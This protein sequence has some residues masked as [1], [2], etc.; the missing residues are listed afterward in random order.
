MIILKMSRSAF[1]DG[2]GKLFGD[3]RVVAP[4]R[5]NGTLDYTDIVDPAQIDLSDELPYKSPKEILFPRVETILRISDDGID[6]PDTPKPTILIGVKHCDITAINVMDKVFSKENNKFS[7]PYYFR[8]RE[9]LIVIGMG[10]VHKKPGCFC[11]ELGIDMTFSDYSDAFISI[12]NDNNIVFL[13]I[14]DEKYESLFSI[15]DAQVL[16]SGSPEVSEINSRVNESTTKN[17]RID[18]DEKELFEE[19]PW[20][21]YS[22]SCLECGI[23]TYIC[24]TCHCFEFRDV[25][26]C[27]VTCRNRCWDSCMYPSFTL[28]ASGH[29]PRATQRERF[30]Q[31][32]LHKYMYVPKNC[33][34]IACT[35]CGRCIRACPGGLNILRAV[36]DILDRTIFSKV[37]KAEE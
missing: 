4:S 26:D 16:E 13:Y 3:Y 30:R 31:R 15:F 36:Q 22:E 37:S 14:L 8:R 29:N 12:D 5:I 1:H 23:C 25:E 11:D 28:H 17:L 9:S 27:G 19:I 24:P 34:V 35:G 18:A 21:L 2:I 20:E 6:V 7:D 10:C 33:S 32:V